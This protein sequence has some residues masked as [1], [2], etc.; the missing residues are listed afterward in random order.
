MLGTQQMLQISR[1]LKKDEKA[2]DIE[3]KFV[4]KRLGKKMIAKDELRRKLQKCGEQLHY[5]TFHE[6]M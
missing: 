3:R 4:P 1:K 6:H 2:Q 5:S